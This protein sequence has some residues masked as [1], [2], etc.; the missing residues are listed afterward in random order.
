MNSA[1][2]CRNQ[3]HF[4]E[5]SKLLRPV[6][7]VG[8]PAAGELV[9][10]RYCV[11]VGR[12][13]VVKLTPGVGAA[14]AAQHSSVAFIHLDEQPGVSKQQPQTEVCINLSVGSRLKHRHR[15]TKLRR[16]AK[17]HTVCLE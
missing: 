16:E 1:L 14:Q 6:A 11:S 4:C 15:G 13:K 5:D 10:I 3:H 7:V 12:Q 9:R 2:Y 17:Q 8:I